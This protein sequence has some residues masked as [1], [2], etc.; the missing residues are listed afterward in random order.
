M[1]ELE[2]GLEAIRQSPQ[3]EGRLEMIV[4]RPRTDEREALEAGELDPEH[5]LVGDNWKTRGTAGGWQPPQADRQLTLMNARV[6]ALLAQTKE[7]WPLAGDVVK[8]V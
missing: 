1:A 4:R 3:D 2:A 7:R 8:K 6:I 5:G